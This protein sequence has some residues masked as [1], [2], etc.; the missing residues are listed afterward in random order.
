MFPGQGSQSPGMIKRLAERHPKMVSELLSRA[1]AALGYSISKLISPEGDADTL[2]MTEH[3]QPALVLASAVFCEAIRAEKGDGIFNDA[4][5]T[6]L[7][8]HSLG[9]FSASVAASSIMLEEALVATRLRGRAMQ[10]AVEHKEWAMAAVFPLSLDS[11]NACCA[12]GCSVANVN[13]DTQI[14]F[15]GE[16]NA[17]EDTCH[18]A[19]SNFGARRVHHLNV[20]APFHSKMMSPAERALGEHLKH[21]DFRDPSVPII[22]NVSCRPIANGSELRELLTKAVTH[23][24]LFSSCIRAARDRLGDDVDFIEAGPGSVLGG[25][26]RRIR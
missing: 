14:V 23:P 8:G 3:A 1:D 20:S 17:V 11:A 18:A 16:R 13:S 24:V 5:N 15:S 4:E 7:V 19:K 12:S 26:V 9:E 22:S 10:K 25:L 21:V 6:V 2:Q